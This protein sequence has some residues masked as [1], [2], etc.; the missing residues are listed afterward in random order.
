MNSAALCLHSSTNISAPML[1]AASS[2]L[3]SWALVGEAAGTELQQA[4]HG[5][6]GGGEGAAHPLRVT[7]GERLLNSALKT[8]L[9]VAPTEFVDW[10]M[11]RSDAAS[12]DAR[13]VCGAGHAWRLE[14]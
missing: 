9:N 2:R 12:D 4:S 6:A 13:P 14:A 5:G 7:A 10:A 1:P 3:G 8:A 11:S